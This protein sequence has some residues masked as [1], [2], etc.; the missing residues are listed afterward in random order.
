MVTHAHEDFILDKNGVR[1][2]FPRKL[3]VPQEDLPAARNGT[4]FESHQ[5]ISRLSHSMS[6]RPKMEWG[7]APLRRLPSRFRY[8][9]HT[10][11]LRLTTTCHRDETRDVLQAR[12]SPQRLETA[13]VLGNRTRDVVER[14]VQVTVRYTSCVASYGIDYRYLRKCRTVPQEGRNRTRDFVMAEA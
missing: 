13:D 2:D 12:N 10:T 4:I 14:G 1:A 3:V 6:S 9:G 8:L 5:S 7:N 11:H